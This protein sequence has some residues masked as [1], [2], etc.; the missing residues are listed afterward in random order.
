MSQYFFWPT[1]WIL[2]KQLF[3]LPS[4]THSAFDLLGYWLGAHSGL[5]NNFLKYYINSIPTSVNPQKSFS[6]D[7]ELEFKLHMPHLPDGL[8]LQK[9]HR[10]LIIFLRP[11]LFV[12]LGLEDVIGVV[13]H[14]YGCDY[15]NSWRTHL[16]NNKLC[17]LIDQY[18]RHQ[19][20]ICS[21]LKKALGSSALKIWICMQP[22]VMASQ[23]L[24]WPVVR[25]LFFFL[26]TFCAMNCKD[27]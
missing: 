25:L 17:L 8:N 23:I 18:W 9:N 2:L 4:I 14:I 16:W 22:C 19:I 10:I 1:S 26:C 6:L 11:L 5:R 7:Y 27:H 12:D 24:L 3:L 21:E 20:P 15:R 13:K